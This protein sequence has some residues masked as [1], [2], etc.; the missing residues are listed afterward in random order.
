ML[1]AL[2]SFYHSSF[3]FSFLI[4]ILLALTFLARMRSHQ[5]ICIYIYDDI[6]MQSLDGRKIRTETSAKINI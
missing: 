3:S 4:L 2:C 1:F 6:D 5:C